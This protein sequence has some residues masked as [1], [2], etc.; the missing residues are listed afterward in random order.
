M[1]LHGSSS[2]FPPS[3]PLNVDG[4]GDVDRSVNTDSRRNNGLEKGTTIRAIIINK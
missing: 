3:K 1:G 4:D 2:P